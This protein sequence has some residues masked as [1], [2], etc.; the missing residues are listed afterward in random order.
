MGSFLRS[1]TVTV[2]TIVM[3]L[4]LYYIIKELHYRYHSLFPVRSTVESINKIS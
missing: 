1:V 3:H 2:V 4:E